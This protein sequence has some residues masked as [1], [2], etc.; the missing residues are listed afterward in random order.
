MSRARAARA[1]SMR[2]QPFAGFGAAGFAGAL[3]AGGAAAAAFARAALLS[4]EL[5][6]LRSS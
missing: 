4:G 1:A 2:R 3:A 5:Y 6:A